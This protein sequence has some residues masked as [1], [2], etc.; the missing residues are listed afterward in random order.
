MEASDNS[1]RP[2]T[3]VTWILIGLAALF[4]FKLALVVLGPVIGILGAVLGLAMFLLLKVGPIVLV[5]WLAVKAFRYLTRDD[6]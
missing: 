6:V 4:I 3:I 2:G 5:G 1:L